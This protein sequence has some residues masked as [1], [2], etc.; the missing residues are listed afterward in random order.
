MT[1][2]DIA[3]RATTAT[4]E[5][6]VDTWYR[7]KA[8]APLR[9]GQPVD[10]RGDVSILTATGNRWIVDVSVVHPLTS[11]RDTRAAFQPGRA[12]ADAYRTKLNFYTRR[13]DIPDGD[14]L[15]FIV[16]TGG[17]LGEP[18][19][20]LIKYLATHLDAKSDGRV[21]ITLFNPVLHPKMGDQNRFEE[22]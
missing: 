14:V 13:Y 9:N 11:E 12:A 8:D 2:F 18:A 21:A 16:E 5:P 17:R 19:Q 7:K 4:F 22:S 3:R 20:K 10:H 1:L 15:P 6:R